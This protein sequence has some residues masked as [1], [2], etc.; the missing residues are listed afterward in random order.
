MAILSIKSFSG[1]APRV[2]AR[3]LPAEGAQTALN[4]IVFEGSLKPLKD[5][6][7]SILTL[8]KAGVIKTIYR[9]GQDV[10]SDSQYWFHWTSDINV[11]RSQIFN[12]TAEWTF[13]T[14]DG[15]PKATYGELALTTSTNY[16]VASIPLGL[17]NPL[18]A[19]S[20]SLG[21]YAPTD[22]S[23]VIFLYQS[24]IDQIDPAEGID[25]SIDGGANFTNIAV[26]VGE[27]NLEDIKDLLDAETG[28]SAVVEGGAVK[29]TSTAVGATATLQIRIET[30]SAVDTT[31]TFTYSGYNSGVINGTSD[32][33][34]PL[35][36]SDTEIASISVNNA[37]D[38]SVGTTSPYTVRRIISNSNSITSG[39]LAKAFT[40]GQLYFT[41]TMIGNVSAGRYLDVGA[42]FQQIVISAAEIAAAGSGEYLDIGMVGFTSAGVV[43]RVI[44]T[45]GITASALATQFTDN[46]NQQNGRHVVDV[47]AVNGEVIITATDSATGS[48]SYARYPSDPTGGGVSPTTSL[49]SASRSV[50]VARVGPAAGGYTAATLASAIN[51]GR[52]LVNGQQTI[53]AGAAQG[54][55]GTS[56]VISPLA[57][58][59]STINFSIYPS[60]PDVGGVSVLFNGTSTAMPEVSGNPIFTAVSRGSVVIFTPVGVGSDTTGVTLYARY[61]KE[62]Q[63][64]G[65]SLFET[66]SANSSS[67][68]PAKILYEAPDFALLQGK[69][70]SV[71]TNGKETIIK[72]PTPANANNLVGL[73]GG[74]VTVQVFGN[75]NPIVIISSVAVGTLATLQIREGTYPSVSNFI[76]LSAGGG[77]EEPSATEARAYVYTYVYKIAGFEFES[78]PSPASDIVNVHDTQ[79]VDLSGFLDAPV[80]YL[81]TSRR[82]Y[83]TVS[84]VYLFV[85]E[86]SFDVFNYT[87]SKRAEELAEEMPSL[88]WY[89]PPVGLK[90]LINLPNGNMA[91]FVGRDVYF[92]VP[93]RPHAWPLQFVQT[94]DFPVV[95]LGRLDT[96]LAVLT[97]GNPYFIQGTDPE[98]MVV[99]KSDLEQA[100][101][102]KRSIVSFNGIVLYVSPD[103]LM[104]LSPGGS[105]NLTEGLFTKDQW[106]TLFS[107]ISIHAYQ[108]DLKYVAFYE[109]STAQ[110]GF[111]FDLTTGK[112][113]VHNLYATSGYTDLQQDQLFV[114]K[115][116]RT[117]RKWDKGINLSYVWKSKKF[118]MPYPISF[119]CAQV[120]AEAYPAT[121]K[122]YANSVLVHTQTVTSRE[123]FRLPVA[124]TRDWELEIEGNTEI[125][126]VDMAQSLGELGGV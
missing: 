110:G 39:D 19:L 54:T 102:S 16:P 93:Y 22:T 123:P 99:V 90:G 37:I 28:I 58:A 10:D 109:T 107:P 49:S 120:E 7:D 46:R 70:I 63:L 82:I 30:G 57:Y 88:T 56:L 65:T 12:D 91:G 26:L 31:D 118:T 89:P 18:S 52:V 101:V 66:N 11:C 86:I 64:G 17:P 114:T 108:T 55:G 27:K 50:V 36:I 24:Q 23:A 61:T 96:T 33:I 71:S 8:P 115:E 13:F 43:S 25:F 73:A 83:R 98:N 76:N 68:G 20:V 32:S 14:G 44:L 41:N 100:C 6:G 79:T 40:Y 48:F 5:L 69:Y 4:S 38:I 59:K 113:I 2:P 78:G 53:F 116:D 51:S 15:A 117:L 125:F 92:C 105:K 106:Q 47:E 42:T 81:I 103:G 95:G 1:I 104:S 126:S 111:I 74:S 29:I 124:S 34:N 9:F 84:G 119:S 87:D 21:P 77:T 85:D 60:D 121:C 112:F 35:I 62:P 97:T 94:L 3:Y 72:V 67:A 45:A 80:G 122:V 75:Q